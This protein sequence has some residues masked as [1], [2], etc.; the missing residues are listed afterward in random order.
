MSQMTKYQ[1]VSLPQLGWFVDPMQRNSDRGN[2]KPLR[3]SPLGRD[4]LSVSETSLLQQRASL[5]FVGRETDCI[6]GLH[7]TV[8]HFWGERMVTTL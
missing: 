3:Q 1:D 7:D 8:F 4:M 5:F 2:T 6:A